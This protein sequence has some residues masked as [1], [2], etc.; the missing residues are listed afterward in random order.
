MFQSGR[1]FVGI[2]NIDLQ[3]LE[4]DLRVLARA[5]LAFFSSFSHRQL[6][7]IPLDLVAHFLVGAAVFLVAARFYR[8]WVA[9]LLTFGLLGLKEAFDTPAKLKVLRGARPVTVTMDSLFDLAA[10]VAGL[11]V[12]YGVVRLLG[13]R[14][15]AKRGDETPRPL[16][17]CS[18]QELSSSTFYPTAGLAALLCLAV[19]AAFRL[20]A[21]GRVSG[22]VPSVVPHLV[23]ALAVLVL[24]R[25]L[26]SGGAVVAIIAALPFLNVLHRRIVADPLNAGNTAFLTLM[27]CVLIAALA[28]RRRVLRLRGAD[29]AVILF[30]ATACFVVLANTARLGWTFDRTLPDGTVIERLRIYWLVPPLTGAG[31]Y[32]IVRNGLANRRALEWALVAFAASFALVAGIGLV[33]FFVLPYRPKIV[34]G[35]MFG[36]APALGVFLSLCLPLF[37]A[38]FVGGGV[39]LRPLFGIAAIL[40]LACVALTLSRSAWVATGAATAI[41]VLAVLWRRDWA[42]GL[43]GTAAAAFVLWAAIWSFQ[44]VWEQHER[45]FRTHAIRGAASLVRSGVYEQSR[46]RVLEPARETLGRSPVLGETGRSAHSL[47]H[48]LALSYG[49]P[50]AALAAIAVLAVLAYGW[51]GALQSGSRFATSIVYGATGSSVAAV[52]NGMGWSVLRRSSVQPFFWFILALVPAALCALRDQSTSAT[53]GQVASRKPP[54]EPTRPKEDRVPLT[55]QERTLLL[56]ALALTVLAVIGVGILVVLS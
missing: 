29:W 48:S 4:H 30:A 54:T 5:L 15:R 18:L 47:H 2:A 52:L 27:C 19:L 35:S 53:F 13:E 6:M 28:R 49:I 43:A 1:W 34:P 31:I 23:A 42:L 17:P 7:G 25:F 46:G 44:Y 24:W 12:A 41:V 10:G 33:E 56:I 32:L 14:W 16:P 20:H 39:R 40:G 45:P 36:A 37:L 38:L 51:A 3:A 11:F 8:R 26:G 50:G 22:P 9:W 55:R 21:I